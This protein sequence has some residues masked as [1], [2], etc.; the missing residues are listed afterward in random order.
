LTRAARY[1]DPARLDR[2]DTLVRGDPFPFLVAEGQLGEPARAELA[3]DFPR[4]AGAGFFPYDRAD[5]GDAIA[6]LV[7]ELTAPEFARALGDRLGIADLDRY[8][9][10]VTI[11]RTLN[12]RHGTI[13]TDSRSK[14]ATALLY[15]N[16]SW[17]QTSAGCLRFLERIDDIDALIAPEVR[18]LYGTLAAFRRAD[19]SFHGHL[20][21][22]GD[23]RVIQV[24][25][26]TSEEEK[27]RK[28]RRGRL[29]RLFKKLFGG[30]DRRLG[31]GRDRNAAHR[32]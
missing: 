15:L 28:T 27:A 23:R 30:L 1:L 10:L 22:E 13:H 25:W 6:D 14:I 12:L 7:D 21:Y 5:C 4:Y 3:A 16:E 29:S 31:A 2:D 8:P 18:P 11:C 9:T 26:L 17:P 24:A 19:N 20:P 32:D